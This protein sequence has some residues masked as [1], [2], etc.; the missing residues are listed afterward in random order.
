MRTWRAAYWLGVRGPLEVEFVDGDGRTRQ[1]VVARPAVWQL[2]GEAQGEWTLRHAGRII[3]VVLLI[4][5]PVILLLLRPRD[6]TA[7]LMIVTLAL[8]GVSSSGPLM[9][10]ERV[11]GTVLGSVLTIFSWMS[12]PIAMP[13]SRS[14]SRISRDLARIC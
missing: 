4:G 14:R 13:L 8:C 5:A 7:R 1:A 10:S 3:L 2:D 9:G 11:L 12:T 6:G